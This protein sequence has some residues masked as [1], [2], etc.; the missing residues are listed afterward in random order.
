[1]TQTLKCLVWDDP[2]RVIDE[3]ITAL[4]I[5]EAVFLDFKADAVDLNSKEKL[6]L[7]NNHLHSTDPDEVIANIF[8]M[9]QGFDSAPFIW[10]HYKFKLQKLKYEV[11]VACDTQAGEVV[12][13]NQ[14]LDILESAQLRVE[15]AIK[16]ASVS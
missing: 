14:L 12:N 11:M 7:V 15:D 2:A 4:T 8:S 13:T 16:I 5:N 6:T 3:V 1:M 10:E 9:A